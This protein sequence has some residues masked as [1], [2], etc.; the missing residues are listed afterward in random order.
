MAHVE[1]LWL[2]PDGSKRPRHGTGRRYRVRWVDPD[3]AERSKSFTRKGDATAFETGIE[4]DMQRGAYRDPAAGRI[5]LRKF[6]AGWLASQMSNESTREAT[7]RRLR[8]HVLPALGSRQLAQITPSAVQG[9]L[10]GLDAAPSTTRVLLSLLSSILSAAVDDGL[11]AS[12]PVHAR[13]VRAPKIERR[14]IEPWPA[15]YVAAVR[16]GMPGH[17]QAMADC[18][19]HLGLRRGEVLG[20]AV[21]DVDWLRRIVRVRRQVK[22][23]GGRLVFGPPKGGKERTV[24]LP[25]LVALALSEHIRQRP[26][27]SV[28]LPWQAPGGKAVTAELLFTNLRGRAIERNSWNEIAWHPALRKAG[29]EPGRD[30]GFHQ[31]RHHYASALL[32]GGVDIRTV[33]GAMGHADPAFTLR[34]YAHLMPDS[35]D[36]IRAAIDRGPATS[37]GTSTARGAEN[38]LM[39][40]A[41]CRCR[42]SGSGHPRPS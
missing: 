38:P 30:Q 42:C 19:A 32:A 24:P 5:T 3:G 22:R 27:A 16:A 13:S 26:P 4:G 15:D 6:S 2:A 28:T 10:R 41:Y 40:C 25:D 39:S 37:D 31:L 14:D 33:A 23:V 36:R 12:N 35:A 9:W 7:E 34:V 20:L 8:L 1:D 21:A 18:G 29:I 11:I 17:Y